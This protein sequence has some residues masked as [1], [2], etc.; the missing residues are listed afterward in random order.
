MSN[1]KSKHRL[2]DSFNFQVNF[3]G[4]N[5]TIVS[6]FHESH[7]TVHIMSNIR[8]SS[9]YKLQPRKTSNLRKEI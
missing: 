5:L 3:N 1:F 8:K 4:L 2:K 6:I 9:I 7:E